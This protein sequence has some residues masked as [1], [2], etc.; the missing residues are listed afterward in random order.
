ME[1][2]LGRVVGPLDPAVLPHIQVL[3]QNCAHCG[4][5]QWTML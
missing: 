1:N 4:T 3:P 5:P 2:K